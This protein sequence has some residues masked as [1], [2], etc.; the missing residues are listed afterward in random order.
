M[1]AGFKPVGSPVYF[2][3]QDTQHYEL[4]QALVKEGPVTGGA[5][6]HTRKKQS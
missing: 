3:H 1:A 5:K 6:K 4:L 2:N